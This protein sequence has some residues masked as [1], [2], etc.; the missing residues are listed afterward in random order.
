MVDHSY[1]GFDVVREQGFGVV[2]V[3]GSLIQEQHTN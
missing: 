2:K 1:Q 3:D